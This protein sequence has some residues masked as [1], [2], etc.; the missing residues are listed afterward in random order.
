MEG[1]WM[2]LLSPKGSQ[3]TEWGLRLVALQPLPTASGGLSLWGELYSINLNEF[4][5]PN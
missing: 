3:T 1:S 4:N 2:H 5:S